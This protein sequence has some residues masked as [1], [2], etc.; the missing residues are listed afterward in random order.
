MFNPENFNSRSQDLVEAFHDA[1]QFYWGRATAWQRNIAI[2]GP[3]SSPVLLPRYRV[4]D[5]DTEEDWL[6]AELK[7]KVLM[8][9]Q[10]N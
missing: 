10:I 2:F 4:Q 1:G 9:R 7:F 5:I 3:T 6:D 8:G